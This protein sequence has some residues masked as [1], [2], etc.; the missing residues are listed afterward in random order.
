M[1]HQKIFTL[2]HVLTNSLGNWR[3][4]VKIPDNSLE[5]SETRLE[6]KSKELFLQFMKN[7]LRWAPEKRKTVRELIEDPWLKGDLNH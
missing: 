2:P 5:K 4:L 3:G 1:H 7:M 6:G